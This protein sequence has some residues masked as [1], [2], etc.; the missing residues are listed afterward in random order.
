MSEQSGRE[1]KVYGRK[2]C[3]AVFARRPHDI[4][5]I[6]HAA[7]V[8]REV[9]PILKWAAAARIPYRELDEEGLRRVSGATRSGCHSVPPWQIARG[10]GRGC[11]RRLRLE[12]VS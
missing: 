3:W 4:V 11:R 1:Q 6:Y 8:R 10:L 12:V 9:G 2:A 7:T 5:R